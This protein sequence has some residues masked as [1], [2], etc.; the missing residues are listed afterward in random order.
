MNLNFSA[1][2]LDEIENKLKDIENIMGHSQKI[3]ENALSSAA[4]V[5]A[6]N[7]RQVAYGG[8]VPGM[9]RGI[10]W[11]EYGQSI[12]IHEPQVVNFSGSIAITAD[13]EM[14][15]R[16]TTEREGWDMAEKFLG[17]NKY[18]RIMIIERPKA[19]AVAKI[20][21]TR[22]FYNVDMNRLKQRLEN[23]SSEESNRFNA[24][25]IGPQYSKGRRDGPP[26]FRTITRDD[27]GSQKWR[28]PPL[29][30]NP[31]LDGVWEVSKESVQAIF[32][33]MASI[34]GDDILKLGSIKW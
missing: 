13:K 8:R 28:Y 4:V 19:S 30:A 15:T 16:V 6:D 33:A 20:L 24:G 12:T 34:I 22:G 21:A 5:V 17:N 27:I 10:N 1:S 14:H 23:P 29:P 25:I 9:T 31:V 26:K 32:E 11:K 7:W 2:G 3:M 18:K